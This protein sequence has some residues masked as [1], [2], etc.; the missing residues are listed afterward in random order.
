[1]RQIYDTAELAVI[2]LDEA[3]ASADNES[4][5]LGELLLSVLDF[6]SRQKNNFTSKCTYCDQLGEVGSAWLTWDP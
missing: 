4:S 2:Y 6:G 1:M 5:P 3:Q